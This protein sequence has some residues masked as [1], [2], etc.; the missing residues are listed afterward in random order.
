MACELGVPVGVTAAWPRLTSSP[1][2]PSSGLCGSDT[3]PPAKNRSPTSKRGGPPDQ[4]GQSVLTARRQVY[5]VRGRRCRISVVSCT[6]RPA[7]VISADR[8]SGEKWWWSSGGRP[9]RSRRPR[10]VLI[11]DN[12]DVPCPA[13]SMTTTFPPGVRTRRHSRTTVAGASA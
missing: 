3:P 1:R 12:R 8:S 13:Q 9:R 10:L 11:H 5:P 6:A 7:S 2:L 4:W